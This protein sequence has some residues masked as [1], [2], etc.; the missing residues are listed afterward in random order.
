[1]KI[2]QIEHLEQLE[3]AA[4]YEALISEIRRII[5]DDK[6]VFTHPF[7]KRWAGVRWRNIFLT[8]ALSDPT[9]LE[10]ADR[11]GLLGGRDTRSV[12]LALCGA[13]VWGMAYLWEEAGNLLKAIFFH[14]GCHS[15]AGFYGR[16]PNSKPIFDL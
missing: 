11:S 12:L 15:D 1:M 3:K 6:T 14:V 2:D 8:E 13:S 16:L 10:S 4:D 5:K 7:V 9:A